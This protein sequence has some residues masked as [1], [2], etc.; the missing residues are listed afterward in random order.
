MT[1]RFK[2]DPYNGF[3]S[4]SERRRALNFRSFCNAIVWVSVALSPVTPELTK[5]WLLQIAKAMS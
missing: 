1:R 3:K 4:D 5:N 2:P